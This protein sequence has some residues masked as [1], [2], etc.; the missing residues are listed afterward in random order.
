MVYDMKIM[1]MIWL[2]VDMMVIDKLLIIMIR[3]WDTYNSFD[4]HD[5]HNL[6]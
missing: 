4:G 3:C 6:L 1:V 5:I 2:T